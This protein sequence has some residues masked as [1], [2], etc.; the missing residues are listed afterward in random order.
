MPIQRPIT[1]KI[2]HGFD[3]DHRLRSRERYTAFHHRGRFLLLDRRQIVLGEVLLLIF[4]EYYFFEF[5]ILVLEDATLVCHP[6]SYLIIAPGFYN[7]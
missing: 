2:R 1:P 4:H 7:K 5:F 3:R 6:E